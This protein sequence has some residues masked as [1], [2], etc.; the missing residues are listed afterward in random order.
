MNIGVVLKDG[1]MVADLRLHS[2]MKSLIRR[3]LCFEVT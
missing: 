3:F 2:I 1:F